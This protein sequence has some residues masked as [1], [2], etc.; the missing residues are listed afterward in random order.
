MMF[1]LVLS[2]AS[3]WG[4]YITIQKYALSGR[5]VAEPIVIAGTML[6]ASI[7]CLVAEIAWRGW[8]RV[9]EEFLLPFAV[10]AGLNIVGVR[11]G[12]RALKLEDA[13]VVA[14]LASATPVFAIFMAWLILGERPTPWGYAGIVLAA[15]GVYIL[16][17]KGK[18][19]ALPRSLKQ[20]LPPRWQPSMQVVLGPILRLASSR[21]AQLALLAAYVGAVSLSFDKLATV[22]SS[23][24]VF[25]GSV[26]A[27]VATVTFFTTS[28]E[29]GWRAMP[30]PAFGAM[31]ALGILLG[32]LAVLMNAGYLYGIVPYVGALK[33]TMILWVVVFAVLFLGERYGGTRFVGSLIIVAGIALMAF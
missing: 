13:S 19:I 27:V 3:L 10:S 16:A 17:L 32:L 25:T 12:V 30:L 14:P 18:E 28:P 7:F 1:T 23:P 22:A 24:M 21:G 31:M 29:G 26:Y 5:N 33:R 9:T 20:A 2:G 11:L 15:V 8:P 6:G 4:A